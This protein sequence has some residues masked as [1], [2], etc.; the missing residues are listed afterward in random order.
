MSMFGFGGEP[1]MAASDLSAVEVRK[2]HGPVGVTVENSGFGL[3]VVLSRVH[4]TLSGE[5][6]TRCSPPGRSERTK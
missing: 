6:A 3:G 2:A 5:A 4:V 1:K